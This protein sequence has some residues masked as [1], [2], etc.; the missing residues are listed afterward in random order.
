[1]GNV[2]LMSGDFRCDKVAPNQAPSIGLVCDGSGT[3]ALMDRHDVERRFTEN[4]SCGQEA[5]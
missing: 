4:L 1:M 5:N 3:G 2:Q